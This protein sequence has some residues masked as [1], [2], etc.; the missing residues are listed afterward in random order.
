MILNALFHRAS[1]KVSRWG[2]LLVTLAAPSWVAGQSLLPLGDDVSEPLLPTSVSRDDVEMF[3]EI[4]HLWKADDGSNVA[5]FIGDFELQ[6]G[7]RRL[8]AREAV[9]WM[10]RQ[11]Y[12]QTAYL[13]FEVMLWRDAHVTEP[14]GTAT[15]GPA[16]FATLQSAGRVRTS[17]DLKS[18][19]S[20]AD[21]TA[22]QRAER[23]RR[24]A[25]RGMDSGQPESPIT[26]LDLRKRGKPARPKVEPKVMYQGKDLAID[27]V[28][29][30]RIVTVIGDVYLFRGAN[31]NGD[32]IEIRAD[33]A[34]VYLA[35]EA[36][37]DAS[38]EVFDDRPGRVRFEG[39]ARTS[40]GSA[41]AIGGVGLDTGGRVEGVYLEGDIVLNSGDRT[42]RASR[43]YYDFMRDRALIL[44]AVLRLYAPDRDVPI[45][46]RADMVR[47]LSAKEFSAGNAMITTSEFHT[48]HYHVGAEELKITDRR[49][50]NPVLPSQT[51]P[52]AG[53]I[54]MKHTTF[55]LGN[56]PL[57][58][59]PYAKADVSGSESS[60]RAIRAGYSQNF[61]AE[62]ET[63]WELFNIL[64][65][66]KPTGVEGQLL[67][68]YFSE[69]GPAVGATLDYETDN[70]FG[71]YRGYV[72][73]DD[74]RDE[75]NGRSRDIIPDSTTR[76][77]SLLRHRAYLPDDWQ[78]T[79]ELSYLS[80]KNFLEQYHESEFFNAKDQESLI[81]VKKQ[82]DNWAFTGLLQ[83]QLMD[84]EGVTERLP[85]FAF[86]LIGEPLGEGATFFSEN[87]AGL[88][89]LRPEDRGLIRNLQLDEPQVGSGTTSRVTSRQELEFPLAIGDFKIVPFAS[90]RGAAWDDSPASGGRQQ[91]FGTYGVRGSM[92]AW[93]V[94][95]DVRN[96]LLDIDGIR[97]IIKADVVA[98]GSNTNLDSGTLYEFDE[99]V[100]GVDEVDGV[101]FGLRQR[102]Q[103]KRG[104]PDRR[105]T[106]DL[107]TFDVELGF[108]NDAERD[109]FTNG[110][111]S[112]T[113]PENS[114]SQNY[115]NTSLIYRMNDTTEL[116]SEMNYDLNDGEVDTL[117]LTYG[118]E[119]SPRLSYLVGYRYVGE[120]ESNVLAA[121]VNYR[122]SEKYIVA[123]REEFDLDRGE[124]AQFDVGVI[125]KFPR[126]YV[127][128]TF[129]VDEIK[130]DFGVS[131]S[132][133]PEGLPAATL[134]TR[135]FT[136]L[137]T[138]TGIR[139]GSG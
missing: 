63:R 26:V 3:G 73:Q 89:R 58:Y 55:R 22:Y 29:G 15:R 5:H 40:A 60:L 7:R 93:K 19:E 6:M 68:D 110:F 35:A 92:Y 139:P 9:V 8:R 117:A 87:R 127:A 131:L 133:W 59:W 135:R 31:G 118:V 106:V 83:Y 12:Q 107:L 14:A 123:V 124:T 79:F 13:R 132:A 56:V 78:L 4:V 113:R 111:V 21:R 65:L 109:E 67:V 86:R 102:W 138:S 30:R 17:A 41:P 51:Q 98:W 126:W 137:V 122:I 27:Q 115:L 129:A 42:V 62:L 128:V 112:P 69:R 74:G 70:A 101:S 71:L 114:V 2:L 105:R 36:E 134:G 66:A 20:T 95:P 49:E 75:L 32:D 64:G 116:V 120:G 94:D 81:F 125:R 82:V 38:E 85:D 77:R 100:E 10:T 52:L 18:N 121:G 37:P 88:V 103:T 50:L 80:D 54:E 48:P 25:R 72:I 43:L 61:G 23:I 130:D 84:F 57:L 47:Q 108:F 39:D 90:I 16:V 99:N 24:A 136:G 96:V 119:R 28:D 11:T 46:V 104:A 44:D 53:T 1:A 45:Y 97:H 34:V 91:V 76:G 33:A